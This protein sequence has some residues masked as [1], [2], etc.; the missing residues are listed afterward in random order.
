MI[1]FTPCL[2]YESIEIGVFYCILGV[3]I[4]ATILTRI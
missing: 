3:L 2:G 4:D 1:I